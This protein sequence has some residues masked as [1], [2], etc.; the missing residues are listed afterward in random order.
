VNAIEQLKARFDAIPNP[1][2]YVCESAK[3]VL[4]RLGLKSDDVK[5][6]LEEYAQR[7]ERALVTFAY[8]DLPAAV[9][10]LD[11]HA[12]QAA[13]NRPTEAEQI[14]LRETI[15]GRAAA[16]GWTPEE[17]DGLI[18]AAGDP[19]VI[20]MITWRSAIVSGQAVDRMELRQSLRTAAY[21]DSGWNKHVAAM[22]PIKAPEGQTN[23]R[24]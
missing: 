5:G 1:Q 18:A 22:P 23:D 21:S 9:T 13:L 24:Q 4:D 17:I 14:A 16:C 19:R 8:S 20:S 2:E 11:Q 12:R 3:N 10:W 7:C 15:H 6:L